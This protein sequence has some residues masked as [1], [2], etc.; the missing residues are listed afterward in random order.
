MSKVPRSA[1]NAGLVKALINRLEKLSLEPGD[2]L[3]LTFPAKVYQSEAMLTDAQ[4]F[5]QSVADMTKHE[6]V[7]VAEGVDIYARKPT[8]HMK[9]HRV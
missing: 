7:I 6:V 1:V 5:A 4:H 2:Q 8:M 9:G 3:V